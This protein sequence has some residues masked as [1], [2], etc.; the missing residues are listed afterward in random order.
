M[1]AKELTQLIQRIHKCELHAV[2]DSP[3]I[4]S[5]QQLMRKLTRPIGETA[6][7]IEENIQLAKQHKQNILNNPL[8]K[9]P[10]RLQQKNGEVKRFDFTRTVLYR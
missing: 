1:S 9:L 5:A 4:N 8:S 10:Q 2:R 3:S 7:L 6:R